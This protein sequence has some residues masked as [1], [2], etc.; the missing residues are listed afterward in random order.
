M[1]HSILF[2]GTGSSIADLDGRVAL[3]CDQFLFHRGPHR[4]RNWRGRTR[5]QF[6]LMLNPTPARRTPHVTFVPPHVRHT[7]NMVVIMV[8]SKYGQT[9]TM[10]I[11]RQINDTAAVN[12]QYP[13]RVSVQLY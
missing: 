13:Y 12:C 1:P 7:M 11:S 6:P 2:T 8:Y 3:L 5:H 10:L 4:R 9:I